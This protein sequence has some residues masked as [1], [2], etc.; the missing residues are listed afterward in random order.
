VA[1]DLRSALVAAARP[2]LAGVAS[3][4]VA[5]GHAGAE[6]PVE[7]PVASGLKAPAG[8]ESLP[9]IAKAVAAAAKGPGIAVDGAEAW[10]D[11]ARGCYGM[12]L[13]MHGEGA[14]ATAILDGIA[15]EGVTTR[16]VVTPQ[17][18]TE[19]LVTLAFSSCRRPSAAES[20]T[21]PRPAAPGGTGDPFGECPE[22]FDKG[23]YKGALR[24]RIASGK[25]TALACFAN[26]RE[27]KACEVP[28]TA[29]LGGLP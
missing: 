23:V 10:G 8:W 13:A 25:V 29:L 11:R 1:I 5:C 24:A 3:A 20:A 2:T 17:N 27:P 9:E 7:Q 15:A 12:W 19:G 16:D 22:G 28:C 21:R 4:L 26:D 18:S 6:P 14:S